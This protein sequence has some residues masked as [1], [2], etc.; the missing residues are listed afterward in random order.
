MGAHSN[1]HTRRS[2]A[3]RSRPP[4][5]VGLGQHPPQRRDTGRAPVSATSR[6]QLRVRR[7]RSDTPIA[8]AEGGMPAPA[9]AA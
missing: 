7:R 1:Q 8:V 2:P 6:Q 9:P 5:I 3:L 4:A